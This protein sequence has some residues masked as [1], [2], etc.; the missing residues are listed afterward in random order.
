MMTAPMDV[1]AHQPGV[2][3]NVLIVDGSYANIGARNLPIGRI[4]YMELRSDIEKLIDTPLKEC[5]YFDHEQKASV[6][7]DVKKLKLA[8]PL[9]PQFQVKTYSTKGYKC[10]CPR[11]DFQ[12]HQ[13]VQKGVDNGIATKMLSLVYENLVDR[14]ILLAGDG[15]FYDT[16]DLIKNVRR[17][18]LW[19][20]GFRSSV[21]PDLQQLASRVIWLEDLYGVHDEVAAS[22]QEVPMEPKDV[23]AV[24]MHD[25]E[26]SGPNTVDDDN[27]VTDESSSATAA[28]TLFVTNYPL[29][30]MEAELAAHF[31]INCGGRIVSVRMPTDKANGALRGYA[32]LDFE[33]HDA[34]QKAQQLHRTD[35]KG[36]KL[37]VKSASARHHADD[38]E[39]PRKRSASTPR[40]SK[41]RRK[42]LPDLPKI[43][44]P[45]APTP[46]TQAQQGSSSLSSSEYSRGDA[47]DAMDVGKLLA[48]TESESVVLPH[49]YTMIKPSNSPPEVIDLCLSD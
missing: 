42:F 9:G 41:K 39:Q 48:M 33:T 35:F 7:P 16:L 13:K 40:G 4:D 17:K 8:P 30:T 43:D 25:N 21:S 23:D 27:D 2:L 45:V 18:D 46:R 34:M 3:R 24:I 28:L 11:C 36:R 44:L 32:F 29:D 31:Q 5:W 20:F 49:K 1:H 6:Y 47:L 37:A 38:G 12:F 14:L 15:D 22:F 26:V 19:V 10:H